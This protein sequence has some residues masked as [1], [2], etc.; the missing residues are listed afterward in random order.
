MNARIAERSQR[1]I[2]YRVGTQPSP[3]SGRG[4]GKGRQIW[5]AAAAF[6]SVGLAGRAHGKSDRY[7]KLQEAL[8]I[9]PPTGLHHL[10]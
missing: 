10:I 8:G 2:P 6:R 3:C 1:T 4:F 5:S 9:P 7:W